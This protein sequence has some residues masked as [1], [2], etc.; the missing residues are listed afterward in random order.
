MIVEIEEVEVET[1]EDT[2]TTVMIEEEDTVVNTQAVEADLE[3]TTETTDIK[4]TI[5]KNHVHQA[6][7]Q[8]EA[9]TEDDELDMG[10][11]T[12]RISL[13]DE[14]LKGLAIIL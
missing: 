5:E 1:A 4:R 11:E 10:S 8:A 2:E 12:G 7:T 3:A 6:L 13:M 14:C 9:E